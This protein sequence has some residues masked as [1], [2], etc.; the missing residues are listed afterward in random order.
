MIWQLLDCHLKIIQGH[1][2]VTTKLFP[3]EGFLLVIWRLPNRDIKTEQEN[4]LSVARSS[5]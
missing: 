5:F 4:N 1:D 2:L 3:S